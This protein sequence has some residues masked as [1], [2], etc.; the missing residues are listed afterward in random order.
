[1]VP[2]RLRYH[3]KH[4]SDRPGARRAHRDARRQHPVRPV[5]NPAY[6]A[7]WFPFP[8][9]S[10]LDWEAL[11]RSTT[12][13]CPTCTAT[14]S[15][16]RTEPLRAQGGDRLLPD[17]PTSELEDE[18]R[19]LGFTRFVET[20]EQRG[21]R[22]RRR[23]EDHDS[24][25]DQPDRRPDRRLV[26][27]GGVRR[28]AAAEPERRPPD[29]PVAVRRARATCTRT[30]C[31]SPARSGTRWCTSCRRRRRRRS[32]SRSATGS[33]TGPGATSTT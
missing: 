3:R 20:A 14:T 13:T 16:P 28:G 31:S 17:Y 27:V 30:C 19:E 25:A 32:A 8:D 18:L 29:R 5:G 1:M 24:G 10:Q 22:A 15:T 7:S 9:N 23:P 21:G 12:C 26:A 4:A 6:F 2:R 33:S 11:G